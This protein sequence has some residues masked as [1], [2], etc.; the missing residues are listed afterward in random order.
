LTKKSR[1][2][3]MKQ[4]ASKWFDNAGLELKGM[5]TE[6]MFNGASYII[7][8]VLPPAVVTQVLWECF[9]TNFRLDLTRLDGHLMPN[10]WKDDKLQLTREIL[11]RDI[12]F[13]PLPMPE[14]SPGETT[15]GDFIIMKPVPIDMGLASPYWTV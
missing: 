12:F 14:G 11:I 7:T 10:D 6:V 8:E 1:G 9:E 13:D 4:E 15:G 2:S 5:P 3:C